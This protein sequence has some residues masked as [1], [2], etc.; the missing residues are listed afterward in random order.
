MPGGKRL[1]ESDSWD[2]FLLKKIIRSET[3]PLMVVD[4]AALRRNIRRMTEIALNADTSLRV[5]TKSVRVP[6][7]LELIRDEIGDTYEGLMTYSPA[8]TRFLHECGFEDFLVAYPRVNPMQIHELV[9]VNREGST[10][11]LM[12]DEPAH[13][14]AVDAVYEELPPDTDPLPVC[15]ELD[16]SYRPFGLTHLGVRRSPIRSVEEFE[17]FYEQVCANPHVRFAGTMGYEAQLAG[18]PD[19][20]TGQPLRNLLI[21]TMKHFSR[22]DVRR[23]RKALAEFLEDRDADNL[24][25]AGGTGS[26][27]FSVQEDGVTEV[28]VGSGFLQSHLFD[29]YQNN[30]NEPAFAFALP[31]TRHPADSIVT[32]QS[33]G[34]IASGPT[35]EDKAPR[36]FRPENV[37]TLDREGFGEVQTPLRVPEGDD[38]SVGDPVFFRPA[39][40]GEIAERF[41]EYLLIDDGTIIERIDTYRGHGQCFY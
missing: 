6:G 2:Y 14:E 15:V 39:K 11:R 25:N 27:R 9:E 36:P 29:D 8:E 13:L 22:L 41:N 23:R 10:A 26:I 1:A 17:H 18:V 37:S 21:R 28:T 5:A 24:V 35:G 19:D 33:G 12:V 20:S 34:F 3:P 32:C 16:V 40:A 7:L 4:R 31:I 38:L 30:D